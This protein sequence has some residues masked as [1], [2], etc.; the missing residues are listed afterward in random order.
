MHNQNN[1]LLKFNHY[2][3]Q[4][5]M[6]EMVTNNLQEQIKYLEKIIT[7]QKFLKNQIIVN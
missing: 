6:D 4:N 2:L 5:K 1:E 3:D 7:L